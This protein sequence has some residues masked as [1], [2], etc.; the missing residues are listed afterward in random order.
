MAAISTVHPPCLSKPSTKTRKDS[1]PRTAS[2]AAHS[3]SS[4]FFLL[5]GGKVQQQMP[6]FMRMH[7]QK[8]LLFPLGSTILQMLDILGA[9]SFFSP[10]MVYAA[11]LQ[12]GAMQ[13]LGIISLF[14]HYFRNIHT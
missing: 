6:G 13:M 4:S 9:R 10:I 8:A 12:N 2:L 3:I 14:I 7:A 1:S 5:L 11:I